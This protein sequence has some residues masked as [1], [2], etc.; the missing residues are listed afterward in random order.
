MFGLS[1]NKLKEYAL[2]FDWKISFPK[3]WKHGYQAEDGQ[4]LFYPKSDDLTFRITS[5][6]AEKEG[7]Y[8]PVETMREAF[9]HSTVNLQPK[10][11]FDFKREGFVIDCMEGIVSENEN[12]IYEV[13]C[14]IAIEGFLLIINVFATNKQSVE[15]SLHYIKTVHRT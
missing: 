7:V 9:L 10:E 3:S 12:D 8:A 13:S 11:D 6:R 2:P 5:L 4:Y 14:G 1:E 15:Q